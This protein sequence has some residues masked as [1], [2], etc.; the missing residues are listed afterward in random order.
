MVDKSYPS[1]SRL[2][3]TVTFSLEQIAWANGVDY[4]II[5]EKNIQ[6]EKEVV[7]ELDY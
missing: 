3:H 7:E 5:N 2:L 6:K 4:V 1:Q